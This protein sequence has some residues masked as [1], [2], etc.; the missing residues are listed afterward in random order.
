MSRK[1]K[2]ADLR[3]RMA[4]AR[5]KLLLQSQQHP[6]LLNDEAD[7]EE[8]GNSLVE[9]KKRPLS[10]VSGGI[11]R[12]P[13]YTTPKTD[14]AVS[15]SHQTSSTITSLGVLT[16][17]G[18]GESSSE[19]DDE[20]DNDDRSKNHVA[21]GTNMTIS[22]TAPHTLQ[23]A[24][25]DDSKH[26]HNKNSNYLIE[27]SSSSIL[28][29]TTSTKDDD[30]SV[31]DEVWDE[32]NAILEADEAASDAAPRNNSKATDEKLDSTISKNDVVDDD[33]ADDDDDTA[34][35][36]N[37]KSPD[38]NG[39]KLELND[40]K[41]TKKDNLYDN[42]DINDMEQTSY[43]A[44]L[45]RLIL[46]KNKKKKHQPQQQR[47][48]LKTSNEVVAP[49]EATS[50]GD[51]YDPSLAWAEDE[52]QEDD[53]Q[54]VEKQ[55]SSSSGINPNNNGEDDGTASYSKQTTDQTNLS[56]T[57]ATAVSMA[58]I[59]RGRR[60]EARMLATRGREDDNANNNEG[61]LSREFDNDDGKWF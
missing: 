55:S 5:S 51:F 30:V 53:V 44:R 31:S 46:L 2:Q 24:K 36:T 47:G 23:T 34:N 59:L 16:A 37:E 48:G 4:E 11:L 18:Y 61:D 3:R 20:D 28:K 13:K 17:A 38:A 7:K 6:S 39:K 50:V 8:G 40:S 15:S 42:D 19:D 14:S 9:T 49:P 58:K 60:D 43:E 10:P 41:R 33:A 35:N 12:K 54:V 1:D 29:P 22:T 52:Q 56:A 57:A 45:A 25:K 27:E 32:F 26:H 21:S